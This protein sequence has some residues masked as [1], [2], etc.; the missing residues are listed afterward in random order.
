MDKVFTPVQERHDPKNRI[1]FICQTETGFYVSKPRTGF[2]SGEFPAQDDADL[3]AVFERQCGCSHNHASYLPSEREGKAAAG[4]PVV[5]TVKNLVAK[6]TAAATV[7]EV[8]AL[9]G[10]DTRAGVVNAAAK[11]LKQLAA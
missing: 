8:N 1:V 2:V 6:I 4:K 3:L 7:E 11:R 9:A 10:T 5:E